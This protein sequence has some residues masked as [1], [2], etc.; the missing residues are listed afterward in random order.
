MFGINLQA[1][2]LRKIITFLIT[3]V[4]ISSLVS[5]SDRL[6]ELPQIRSQ[7]S[8]TISKTKISEVSPPEIIQQLRQAID[9]YQPQITI[10]NPQPDQ[11]FEDNDI[12]LQLQ[13]QDLPIFKS[14][15]DLGPYIEVILDDRHYT[16]IY[17]INEPLV[18]S[19][20]E[21]GTHTLRVFAC[22]PWDESFKNEGA[23]AQTTFHILTKTAKN[24]PAP[25]LPLL[26]YNSPVGSYG[27]EPIML[28]YYLTNA[29]L[30][31]VAQADAEDEI[32]DWRIRVTVNGSSFITDQWQSI[33]LQGF[34]PGKNWVKL[35]YIDELGNPINNVYN[36]TVHLI[37][38][39]PGGEDAL[40]KIIRG[41]ISLKEAFSIIDPEYIYEELQPEVTPETEV[42][43]EVV[44]LTEPITEEL[45]EEETFVEPETETE[46]EPLPVTEPMTEELE[47]EE[48]FV[49]PETETEVEPLPVT[50]PITEELEEEETFVEPETETQTEPVPVTEPITEELDVE[51]TFVEPETEATS[52][53]EPTES[54]TQQIL[55]E[56]IGKL[57]NW[58]QRKFQGRNQVT[59]E[60]EKTT[61]EETLNLPKESEIEDS[62]QQNEP[63]NL[64]EIVEQLPIPQSPEETTVELEEITEDQ[65]ED[66]VESI[67]PKSDDSA[68]EVNQEI[69]LENNSDS[70][71][72][73][74]D[75]TPEVNPEIESENNSDSVENITE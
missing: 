14:D 43:V 72:N 41:E 71:E 51:E 68:L 32:D 15:L 30:H 21:P 75:S 64:P 54:E 8:E 63:S 74:D 26:T 22:S 5:C 36:N 1:T 56:K 29:P 44:P 3:V 35:E 60:Q 61:L 38:Y 65:P 19:D 53:V 55:K 4:L 66:V 48:T 10:Q 58:V 45:Q 46:V 24:N 16:K 59:T 28:D 49:E 62:L 34:H 20:L 47:E 69:E 23:Y 25:N 2:Y 37:T 7:K 12:T 39:K 31:S 67:L 73:L 18:L 13:V 52:K 9:I 27:E 57:M 11:K 42:E 70:V 33:Y 40:S 17:D 50:E 6:P